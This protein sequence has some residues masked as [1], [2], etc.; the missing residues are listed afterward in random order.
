MGAQKLS[1][2]E[3]VETLNGEVNEKV[4]FRQPIKDLVSIVKSS[5]GQEKK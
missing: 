4:H 2:K 5:E 1:K 3:E